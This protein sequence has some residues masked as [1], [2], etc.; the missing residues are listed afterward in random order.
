MASIGKGVGR[1]RKVFLLELGKR[2]FDTVQEKSAALW[3]PSR[4]E[5]LAIEKGEG[6]FLSALKGAPGPFLVVRRLVP[7]EERK[8]KL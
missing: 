2:P 3:Q 4:S 7:C 8:E 1:G 5:A 6:S